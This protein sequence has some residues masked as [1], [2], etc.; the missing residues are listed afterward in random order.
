VSSGQKI[1]A[2]GAL[3]NAGGWPAVAAG[4]PCLVTPAD[5]DPGCWATTDTGRQPG[6][7]SRVLRGGLGV[8]DVPARTDD[9]TGVAGLWLWLWLE[10]R[11]LERA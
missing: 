2:W 10:E 8:G 7:S 11:W 3:R 1:E 5:Q 9:E 6:K 4:Q